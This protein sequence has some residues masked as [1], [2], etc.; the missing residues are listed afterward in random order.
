MASK[1]ST[2]R[3]AMFTCE[4]IGVILAF[5]TIGVYWSFVWSL[6]ILESPDDGNMK[7]THKAVAQLIEIANDHKLVG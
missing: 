5:E 2:H 6:L 1:A 7:N 3:R 4:A